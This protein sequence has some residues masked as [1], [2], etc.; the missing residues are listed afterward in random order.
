MLIFSPSANLGFDHFTD[1]LYHQD[2]SFEPHPYLADI[3][4]QIIDAY[5]SEVSLAWFMISVS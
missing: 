4:T 2:S 5:A 3:L 1:T